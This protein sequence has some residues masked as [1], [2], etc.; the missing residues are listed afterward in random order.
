MR[1][2]CLLIVLLLA[3]GAWADQLVLTDGTTL[4]GTVIKEADG[5]WIKLTDGST[6]TLSSAE[7]KSHVKGNGSSVAS[8][9]ADFNATKRKA[10]SAEAPL[11]AVAAWQKYVEANPGDKLALAELEKWKKLSDDGAEKINGKWVGG[12]E[13]KA[14]IAK[15]NDLIDQA[16][17]DFKANQT[18]AAVKKLDEAR[19]VYPNAERAYFFL[20]YINLTPNPEQA[21]KNFEQGLRLKPNSVEGLNNLGIAMI[22]KKEFA[23]GL[24]LFY[25]AAEKEDSK[26]L[27]QNLVNAAALVPEKQRD[28]AGVKPAIEASKILGAKYAIKGP[29]AAF[30][31]M[32][33]GVAA[34][35]ADSDLPPGTI[36]SGTGFV[37][38]DDGLILTN[39][40]VVQGGQDLL[41]ILPGNVRKSA[42]VVKID[43]EQDLAL[44]QVKMDEKLSTAALSKADTPAE[45]AQV[46]VMGYPLLDRM[47]GSIKITQGIVSGSANRGT[48]ADILTDAKV[49]PGNSGGPMLDKHGQVVGIVTMKSLSTAT[50]DSYGM[51]ISAGQIRKFLAKENV[52]LTAPAAPAAAL[53]AEQVAS[54]VKPATVCILNVRNH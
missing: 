41:V 6:R 29:S 43:D 7:V 23:R 30:S 51:A 44:I 35:H 39:R 24:N 50:E 27:A 18:L 49:N 47:G 10:D 1:S 20:G 36:S 54:Q 12:D 45:G 4:E 25:Q 31:L 11:A 52:V 42:Q 37:I 3:G 34:R 14:M 53:D 15:S 33:P 46:F 38:R 8:G 40:H 13:R 9:S 5:Y 17:K 19:K 48:G 26:E 32:P 22:A 28:G 21:I 16:L 2:F